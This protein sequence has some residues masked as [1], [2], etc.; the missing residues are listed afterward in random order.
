MSFYYPNQLYLYGPEAFD[1]IT[2]EL[3]WA[4]S[5]LM[6]IWIVIAAAAAVVYLVFY[7]FTSLS[8][9]TMA[10]RRGFSGAFLAWVPLL[11]QGV[12]GRIASDVHRQRTG[13]HI[14]YGS[15]LVLL[16]LLPIA[17]F[18]VEFLFEIDSSLVYIAVILAYI[19]IIVKIF[20]LSEIYR[21]YTSHWVGML[22]F[23]MLFPVLRPIFLIAIHKNTPASVCFAHESE[24]PRPAE[25]EAEA[26]QPIITPP[27]APAAEAA[28][29]ES[30]AAPAEPVSP[31]PTEP[32]AQE[33][34]EKDDTPAE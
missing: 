12:L 14:F 17:L 24:P 30:A 2:P 34:A 19:Q 9:Y 7:V 5:V 11:R 15:S 27:P 4:L 13:K 20:A 23:S 21:D 6:R 3:Q 32:E 31:E 8:L 33:P 29:V 10:E 28:P 26:A 16:T 1:W 22:I 25:P 18:L